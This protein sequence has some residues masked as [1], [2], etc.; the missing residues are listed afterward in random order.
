MRVHL[1]SLGCAK[2]RVDSEVMVGLLQEAGHQLVPEAEGADVLVVNTCGFIQPATE[3]SIEVVLELA[4]LREQGKKLVVTGCMVQRYGQDLADELPEVD[5][6]LGTG[7]FHHIVRAVEGQAPRSLIGQPSWLHDEQT[8]R[9]NTWSPASA[10]LKVS[11]GCD[12][13]CGFCTIPAIR[14][15]HRSRTQDSLVAEATRLV[16]EGVVELNVVGQDTTAWGRDLPGRPSLSELLRALARVEGLRWLRLHY[17]WPAQVSE[18]LLRVLHEEPVL[19]RYLDVPLQH[20]QREVLRAMRRPG[21]AQA[22]SE[23]VRQAREQVPGLALRSTF[24]V[25]HPGET[26]A[27]F[28][29]LCDWVR[30]HE[31]D[32]VGV[33]PFWPEE[34]TASAQLDHRLP[35]EEAKARAEHLMSMQAQISRERLADRVGEVVDVLVE[36]YAEESELLLR[37]RTEGQAP[38]VDGQVY[39]G[40]APEDVEVGQIRPLLVTDSGDHDLVGEVLDIGG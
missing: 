35:L 19:C 23:L 13:G 24:I 34:G 17:A 8:P 12:H 6:F 21:H 26:E 27:H 4:R 32:H 2:N 14:G 11:E 30:A 38:E 9:V 25:G 36:G 20:S 37:G 1:V 31:L 16:G 40:F 5:H 33:F 28:L 29:A 3:E 18:E 7:E 15:K 22:F 10:Y 39:I